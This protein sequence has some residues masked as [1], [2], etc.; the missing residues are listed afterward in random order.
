MTSHTHLC[1]FCDQTW[2]CREGCDTGPKRMGYVVTNHGCADQQA[3]KKRMAKALSKTCDCGKR[4]CHHEREPYPTMGP[5]LV[6]DPCVWS[7]AEYLEYR[8]CQHLADKSK[9]KEG[10]PTILTRNKHSDDC[11]CKRCCMDYRRESN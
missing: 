8:Y 7:C 2:S 9:P 6:R 3:W 5:R 11:V 10:N 1:K 4:T